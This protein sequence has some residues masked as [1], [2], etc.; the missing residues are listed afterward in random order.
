LTAAV[1]ISFFP[2]GSKIW[3]FKYH[4]QGREKLIS[5]GAYPAVSLKDARDKAAKAR[6]TLGSGKDPSVE[7][8]QSKLQHKN[9]F[10]TIAREW[11]EK[12]VPGWSARYA[13]RVVQCQKNF[14]EIENKRIYCY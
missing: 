7:R 9:T 14:A 1:C 6:K 10:E 11:H 13:G 2:S 12:Q 3:R 8:Q 5:L 4:F